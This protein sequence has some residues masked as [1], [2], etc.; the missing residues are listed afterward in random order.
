MQPSPEALMSK[1][2]SPVLERSFWLEKMFASKGAVGGKGLEGNRNIKYLT[3][4]KK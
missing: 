1:S 4:H 3:G 2:G